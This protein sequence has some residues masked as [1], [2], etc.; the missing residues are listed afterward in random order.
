MINRKTIF[1][2]LILLIIAGSYLAN[3]VIKKTVLQ[4]SKKNDDLS[5]KVDDYGN[6]TRIISLAPNITETLFTLGL[7]ERIVGVTRFCKYPA[8]ALKKEKV[9]GFFDP[10]YEAIAALKP[11]LVILLPEHKN[12]QTYLKE[13]RLQSLVVNN[14]LINEILDTITTIGKVCAV[15]NSANTLVSEI[16]TRM[17][18]IKQ[19]TREVKCP[20]VMI[21]I[22]RTFGSGSIKEVSISGKN[23]F[24]DELITYA[25]GVNVY[26]RHDIAFPVLS[27]EG[28]LH[29]NPEFIIEM[30]P[31]ISEKGLEK[32]MIIKEWESFSDVDAVKNNRIYVLKQDYAVIPGPR[33]ILLL[34]DLARILHPE[35]EWD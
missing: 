12:I 9:G 13:L 10:N 1:T 4:D 34:E 16:S 21:S 19:R 3:N 22:G 7:G 20:R 17:N 31:D 8:E 2:S 15:E 29:L 25:G 11:D 23:T 27:K 14:R 26:N 18:I 5:L 32:E 24:Y 6:Y 30:V 33:F 28:I 35:I